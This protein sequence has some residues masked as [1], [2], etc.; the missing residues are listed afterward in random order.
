MH[1]VSTDQVDY[2]DITIKQG[3]HGWHYELY[4]K[5]MQCKDTQGDDE[6]LTLEH[7]Q[8]FNANMV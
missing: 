1:E 6:V 5:K 3:K 4:H 8:V 7:N 2:L